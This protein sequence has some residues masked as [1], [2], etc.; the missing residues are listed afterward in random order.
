MA[1]I[2][3]AWLSGTIFECLNFQCSGTTYLTV[4]QYCS[5]L[6]EGGLISTV[7]DG[8]RLF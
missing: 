2:E 6:I 1:L 3:V 5:E 7:I 4:V 8:V